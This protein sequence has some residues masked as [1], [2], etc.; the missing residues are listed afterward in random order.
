V[1]LLQ[2]DFPYQ[3]PFGNQ[4]TE[5][6][7]ELAYSVAEEPGCLWKIWTENETTKEAGGIYLFV[8]EKTLMKYVEMHTRR[9]NEFGITDI[10]LKTFNVNEDLSKITRAMLSRK[11]AIS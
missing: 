2:I 8:D 3:G 9:L 10:N 4:M 7:S 5:A 11:K 6:M 1:K